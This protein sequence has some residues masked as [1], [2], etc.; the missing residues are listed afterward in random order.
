MSLVGLLTRLHNVVTLESFPNHLT[1]FFEEESV[2]QQGVNYQ[3]P[4]TIEPVETIPIRVPLAR[5]YRGSHYQMTRRS[6]IL[7]RIHT[8]SGLIAEAY[9]GDEDAGLEEIDQIIHSEIV[10]QIIGRDI[11]E[12]ERLWELARPATWNILRDRRLGLVAAA[13]IDTAVWDGVGKALNMPL[14]RLWGGYAT[15]LPVITIGA[16]TAQAS[17]SKKKWPKCLRLDMPE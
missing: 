1:S 17:R 8:S 4:V 9:A 16:I 2:S 7:T 14:H 6:T 5:T 3:A 12:T 11:F 10:P 13:C 15:S